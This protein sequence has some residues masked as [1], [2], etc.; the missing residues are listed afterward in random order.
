MPEPGLPSG[1]PPMRVL[2]V[3][4]LWPPE[5]VGGAEQYAARLAERLLAAGHEVHVLT[6]GTEDRPGITTVARI[7]ATP[8]AVSAAAPVALPS[9]ARCSSSAATSL[10]TSLTRSR[11]LML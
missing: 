2:M 3:S 10:F 1:R 7:S 4:N 9:R 11:I 6:L 8:L 5:V